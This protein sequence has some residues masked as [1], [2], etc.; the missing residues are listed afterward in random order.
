M[1]NTTS[2]ATFV[3]VQVVLPESSSLVE[4]VQ[5]ASPIYQPPNHASQF[6]EQMKFTIQQQ[7]SVNVQVDFQSFK[8]SVVFVRS[9]KSMNQQFKTVFQFVE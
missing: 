9:I 8:G 6:V 2:C 1:N 4:S 5:L 7:A 3:T